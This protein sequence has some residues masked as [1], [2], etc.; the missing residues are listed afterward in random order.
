MTPRLGGAELNVQQR[1]Q[2]RQYID[3]R[4]LTCKRHVEIGTNGTAS[5]ISGS[6]FPTRNK[7]KSHAAHIF[8]SRIDR[9]LCRIGSLRYAFHLHFSDPSSLFPHCISRGILSNVPRTPGSDF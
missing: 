6:L 9:T 1:G 5:R 4:V 2:S 7:S 3:F 8:D